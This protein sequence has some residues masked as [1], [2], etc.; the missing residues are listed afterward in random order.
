MKKI[1]LFCEIEKTF[2]NLWQARAILCKSHPFFILSI[3]Q[4]DEA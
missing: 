1:F 2:L 3:F 4:S